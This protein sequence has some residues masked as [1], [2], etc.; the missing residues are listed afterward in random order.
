LFSTIIIIATGAI[1]PFTMVGA[2]IGLVRLPLSYFFWLIAIL[3]CYCLLA[4]AVKIW[5]LGRFKE[6]ILAGIKYRIQK[7][8]TDLTTDSADSA[9]SIG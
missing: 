1:L 6:W 4:Q 9:D 8:K 7:P 2:A 5:F 3:C